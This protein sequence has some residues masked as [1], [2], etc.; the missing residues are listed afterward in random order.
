MYTVITFWY[1]SRTNERIA[2]YGQGING[3]FPEDALLIAK[4]DIKTA[5]PW[6][7]NFGED[8]DA[9]RDIAIRVAVYQPGQYEVPICIDTIYARDLC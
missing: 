6:Y 2:E 5:L 9:V 4:K 3:D 1:N 7:T 8:K